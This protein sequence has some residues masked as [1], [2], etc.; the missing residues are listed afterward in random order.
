MKIDADRAN[1]FATKHSF[2]SAPAILIF[3]DENNPVIACSGDN[4]KAVEQKLNLLSK[5]EPD[6][7]EQDPIDLVQHALDRQRSFCL[8]QKRSNPL[9]NCFVED[10]T[11]LKSHLDKKLII[12]LRFRYERV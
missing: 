8:N 4:I 2:A 6:V 5:K 3:G 7:R 11:V 10:E 1:W 9:T 12:S